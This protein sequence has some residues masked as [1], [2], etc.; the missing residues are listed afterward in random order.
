MI[1]P[2]EMEML[3]RLKSAPASAN[4]ACS[5]G[6]RFARTAGSANSTS[7]GFSAGVGREV[8]GDATGFGRGVAACG[9][10]GAAGATGRGGWG[11][12][13]P[14]SFSS[15]RRSSSRSNPANLVF[16]PFGIAL[17]LPAICCFAGLNVFKQEARHG[18][19][20]DLF[21]RP[22]NPKTIVRPRP[23]GRLSKRWTGC[24]QSGGKSRKIFCSR[25]SI[26]N[27]NCFLARVC[28]FNVLRLEMASRPR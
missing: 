1:L 21:E 26:R 20:T 13:A 9:M 10:E 16:T 4:R 3:P 22:A 27:N 2:T 15:K 7:A 19:A 24:P 14:V 11:M 23:G 12:S 28:G 18:F 5:C 6:G 17:I 25:R 8:A